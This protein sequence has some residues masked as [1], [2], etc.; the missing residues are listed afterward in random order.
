MF[1][2]NDVALSS[3]SMMILSILTDTSLRHLVISFIMFA[4]YALLIIANG[5]NYQHNRKL[6]N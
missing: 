6:F 2:I 1:E 5:N 4:L 3:S